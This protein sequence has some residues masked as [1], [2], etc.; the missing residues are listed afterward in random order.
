MLYVKLQV[1]Y[2]VPVCV[3]FMLAAEHIEYYQVLTV[4]TPIHNSQGYLDTCTRPL[5]KF[6]TNVIIRE[7][8][9]TLWQTYGI[10]IL[11]T[12]VCLLVQKDEGR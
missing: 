7:M 6:R 10:H 3:K 2:V 8:P 1:K 5:G 12:A 4:K 9:G 11:L